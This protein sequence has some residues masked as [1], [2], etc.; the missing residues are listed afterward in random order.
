MHASQGRVRS[1]GGS[2]SSQRRAPALDA[3]ASTPPATRVAG[4]SWLTI[5]LFVTEISLSTCLNFCEDAKGD[6]RCQ[7]SDCVAGE[8]LRK[9]SVGDCDRCVLN[10]Y[11][12]DCEGGKYSPSGASACSDCGVGTYS[13]AG[14]SACVTCGAGTYSRETI[15]YECVKCVKGTYSGATGA[16]SSSTCDRCGAGQYPFGCRSLP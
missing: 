15:K 9:T 13:R 6:Y 8:Y 3:R 4:Q 1:R 12:R 14:A 10:T 16:T 11:C 2:V 5:L 7:A